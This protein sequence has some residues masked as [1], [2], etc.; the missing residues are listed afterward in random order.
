[1]VKAP[2]QT[3][4]TQLRPNECV[5]LSL[6]ISRALSIRPSSVRDTPRTSPLGT[7]TTTSN[8]LTTLPIC[9]HSGSP[10]IMPVCQRSEQQMRELF[11]ATRNKKLCNQEGQAAPKAPPRPSELPRVSPQST[12]M[13]PTTVKAARISAPHSKSSVSYN[14]PTRRPHSHLS[15]VSVSFSSGHFYGYIQL[16]NLISKISFDTRYAEK[17]FD[18]FLAIVL[19]IYC[20]LLLGKI[21]KCGKLL[22]FPAH[23]LFSRN[24][25]NTEARN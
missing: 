19:Y 5:K 7:T 21:R 9:P 6:P 8:S 20:T 4:Q 10:S 3:S 13:E 25:I 24:L 18:F 15:G 17:S 14:F 12:D 11:K 1:M 16:T 23:L 2:L 22:M